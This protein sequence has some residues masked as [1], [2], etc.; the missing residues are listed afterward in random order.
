MQHTL[1]LLSAGVNRAFLRAVQTIVIG[2]R[3]P[4]MDSICSAIGC[5]ELKRLSGWPDVIAARCGPTNPRIDFALHRFGVEPPV[6]FSDL[7]PRVCDVM[8]PDVVS[9]HVDTPIYDAIQ[10]I[11]R[12]QLRGL[13]V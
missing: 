10:I 8:P 5:A 12:R 1:F 7:S 2:H 13:P 6:L 4:D 9:V 11:D 3:N